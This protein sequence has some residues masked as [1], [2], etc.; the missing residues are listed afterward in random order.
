MSMREEEMSKVESIPASQPLAI[1]F[2][3]LSLGT[4]EL[5]A[6][7]IEEKGMLF[8]CHPSAAPPPAPALI[9]SR[10]VG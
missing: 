4:Q 6:L 3:N 7:S 8:P 2:L 10:H 1:A 5:W 9:Y